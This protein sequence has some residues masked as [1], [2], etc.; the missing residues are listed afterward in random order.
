MCLQSWL[1]ATKGFPG[2]L[3]PF[4]HCVVILWGQVWDACH[5]AG[6]PQEQ[7]EGAQPGLVTYAEC[8]RVFME[9]PG[10]LNL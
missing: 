4:S 1:P 6:D 10:K 8:A 9:F 5:T 2:N 3:N 7:A